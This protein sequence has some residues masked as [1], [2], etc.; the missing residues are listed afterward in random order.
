MNEYIYVLCLIFSIWVIAESL[1]CS[2]SVG[3]SMTTKGRTGNRGLG[4]TCK[5]S[6]NNLPGESFSETGQ[7]YYRLYAIYRTEVVAG[8]NSNLC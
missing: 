2:W 6:G 5:H 8:T 7:S 1:F 4:T 3:K